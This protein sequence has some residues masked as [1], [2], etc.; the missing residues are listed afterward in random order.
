MDL[1]TFCD[2]YCPIPTVYYR[3]EGET[4]QYADCGL[5]EG[6]CPLRSVDFSM[7]TERGNDE[8]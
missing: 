1:E 8:L 2:K 4:D 6:D 7:V 5:E 3:V